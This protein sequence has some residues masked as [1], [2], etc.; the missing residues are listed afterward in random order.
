MIM[1]FL[2]G[3]FHATIIL[4]VLNSLIDRRVKDVVDSTKTD[5]SP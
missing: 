1:T 4:W 3:W 2:A 5:L